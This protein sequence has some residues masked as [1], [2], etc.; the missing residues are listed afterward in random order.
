MNSNNR[1]VISIFIIWLFTVS[2]I[3][4]ILSDY[5]DWFLSFTWLNLMVYM[6][7]ILWNY[8][9]NKRVVLVLLM[10][11]WLGMITEYL[12]VN[13]G[14]IFGNYEYGDNL[15]LKIYGVPWIIGINWS[16]L[17]C[18]SAAIAKKIHSNMLISS[19]LGAL[20]MVLLDVIIEVSAP[21]FD[22]WEFD[23]NR[24][25]IQNYI[26]WFFTA[27]AAHFLIQKMI[28]V[29]NFTISLHIFIAIFV[30]FTSFL[31]F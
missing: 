6:F 2:G 5:R 14:L 29:F 19:I 30:F 28:K 3:I 16:I 12:G 24:V 21:R 9:F 27:W 25:P 13:Y 11:F 20:L 26:G 31:I 22:F 1:L 18:T 7:L 23:N 8:D 10:P 17:T 15:G 4:G